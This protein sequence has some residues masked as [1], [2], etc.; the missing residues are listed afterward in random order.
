MALLV[1]LGKFVDYCSRT[2]LSMK[3]ILRTDEWDNKI[4][5]EIIWYV[6]EFCLGT[7]LNQFWPLKI[8]NTY[9]LYMIKI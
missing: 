2:Y 9:S 5:V 6:Y 8:E 3:I 7:R 1:S 4:G